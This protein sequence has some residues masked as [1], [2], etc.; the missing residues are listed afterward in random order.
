MI[1]LADFPTRNVTLRPSTP[2]RRQLHFDDL[3]LQSFPVFFPDLATSLNTLSQR[4]AEDGHF[5]EALG[6]VQEAV[7]LQRTLAVDLPALAK[8]LHD[9]SLRLSGM[10]GSEDVLESAKS[11]VELRRLFATEYP[12]LYKSGLATSL[13]ALSL[14][15]FYLGRKEVPLSA[16]EETIGMYEQVLMERPFN[17]TVKK[18]FDSLSV[19]I[20][21]L[22]PCEDV[23]RHG[24]AEQWM[25]LFGSDNR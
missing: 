15:L 8:S 22:D 20:S 13:D 9:L 14:L 17:K 11:A 10:G 23:E 1:F 12:L 2:P 5:T 21:G 7:D 4:L 25:D 18:S 16:A 24:V 19:H 6:A 3:S